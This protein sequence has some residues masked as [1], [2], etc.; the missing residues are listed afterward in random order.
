VIE[1]LS[2]ALTAT[3]TR[4]A[5]GL[6][7]AEAELVRARAR[8][9]E[10]RQKLALARAREA[11][12][13]KTPDRQPQRE[14]ARPARIAALT[15]NYLGGAATPAVPIP[16]RWRLA[17]ESMRRLDVGRFPR[18]FA[19][20][21]VMSWAGNGPHSGTH[22]GSTRA[23]EAASAIAD[24]IR[25]DSIVVEELTGAEENLEV[26]ARVTFD[27]AAVP[28][29]PLETTIHA[30]FRFDDRGRITLLFASPYDPHAVDR[31]LG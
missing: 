19:P 17:L 10:L 16:R 2:G 6:V 8:C 29:P 26:L 24:R 9:K 1:G 27:N 30:V 3:Q 25:P 4:L 11:A 23:A 5:S 22:L 21:I 12:A 20:S 31:Y 7:D 18:I 14:M 13:A 15:S 28:R